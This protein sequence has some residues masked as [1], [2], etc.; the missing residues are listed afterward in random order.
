MNLS[1]FTYN[2]RS[3]AITETAT[4]EAVGTELNGAL[5]TD[6]DGFLVTNAEIA[7]R[8]YHGDIAVHQRVIPINPGLMIS[9]NNLRLVDADDVEAKFNL[10][11]YMNVEQTVLDVAD[12]PEEAEITV[13][14]AVGELE[15]V[16]DEPVAEAPTVV[17]FDKVVK[18]PNG[19]WR[20][21]ALVNG[22]VQSVGEF[23]KRKDAVRCAEHKAKLEEA[24]GTS[25]SE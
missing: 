1:R 23:R 13:E 12:A 8:L 7:W 9:I 21:Y 24:N 5:V 11:G 14:E 10:P 15:P 19:K 6:V 25:N 20:A 16:E 17:E 18:Q 22:K 2:H 4:G 3:G